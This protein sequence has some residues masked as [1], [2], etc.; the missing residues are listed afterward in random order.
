MNNSDSKERVCKRDNYGEK[1]EKDENCFGYAPLGEQ[2][3]GG[4]C[5]GVYGD[6]D[7]CQGKYGLVDGFFFN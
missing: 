6:Q 2:C 5:M 4:V 1:C 3:Q 7:Q